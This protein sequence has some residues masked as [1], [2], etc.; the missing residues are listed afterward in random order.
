MSVP[1][2]YA[3]QNEGIFWQIAGGI[4]S[5]VLSALWLFIRWA[6]VLWPWTVASVF[7]VVAALW[8]NQGFWQALVTIPVLL[9][10][11]WL[12]RRTWA[13][14]LQDARA[15]KLKCHIFTD[16]QKY[17]EGLVS[18]RRQI[19]VREGAVP[20]VFRVSIQSDDG[21][22]DEEVVRHFPVLASDLRKSVVHVPDDSD[23]GQVTAHVLGRDMLQT[24]LPGP[25]PVCAAP[26]ASA[27]DWITIGIDTLAEPVRIP[28][29]LAKAGGL[30]IT[31]AGRAG[32]GKGSVQSQLIAGAILSNAFE[33]W[34][35]DP[36][37]TEMNWAADRA[38]RYATEADAIVD[39]LT[40]LRD[41]VRNRQ[42]Q[43]AA[44]GH[45]LWDTSVHGR[46]LLFVLDELTTVTTEAGGLD[47]K[48][49]K[50]ACDALV[51]ISARARS[52]GVT[53][54]V[55]TQQLSTE[56]IPSAARANFDLRL[57]MS[58]NSEQDAEMAIPGSTR[59]AD[60]FNPF[61]IGGTYNTD[62]SL[63]TAGTFVLGGMFM[64]KGRSHFIP[65]D[66]L[67]TLV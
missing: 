13:E 27:H 37:Q 19:V 44:T 49:V 59:G 30:R 6:G 32:S 43:V 65:S 29:F 23:D 41:A 5:G 50:T 10:C 64:K 53:L 15:Y 17:A 57:S 51:D 24:P 16:F 22:A 54:V 40:D 9:G 31:I 35:A 4:F 48:T 36:K 25:V 39:T 42:A 45:Q 33:L 2:H 21:H 46:P 8:A 67:R 11:V 18:W 63:S 14:T 7:G 26:P 66:Q 55:T 61:C 1:R 47:R 62:G 20:D 38:D 52:A 3:D 60:L 58:V 56:A 28:L 34:L 12:V